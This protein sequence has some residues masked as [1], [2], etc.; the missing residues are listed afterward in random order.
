MDLENS[1]KNPIGD[2]VDLFVE[3]EGNSQTTKGDVLTFFAGF[4][5]P[6]TMIGHEYLHKVAADIVHVPSGAI[7]IGGEMWTKYHQIM[8]TYLGEGTHL[9]NAFIRAFPD[10][11]MFLLSPLLIAVGLKN[12]ESKFGKFVTGVG[13]YCGLQ[14]IISLIGA[15]YDHTDV[16]QTF[17]SL[18]DNFDL[19]KA[20][21]YVSVIAFNILGYVALRNAPRLINQM[22][23]KFQESHVSKIDKSVLY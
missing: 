15:P 7:Q 18:N 16:W 11:T 3:Q 1:L 4:L 13:M 19:Q 20:P 23:S 10:T 22:C 9:Q 8:G 6:L 17:H 14:Y 12:S 2:I 5:N 21:Y